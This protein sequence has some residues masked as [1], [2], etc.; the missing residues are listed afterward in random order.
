[1]TGRNYNCVVKIETGMMLEA[2]NRDDLF[3][4]VKEIWKDL[5]DITLQDCEIA[6]CD[7]Q[8]LE[9]IYESTQ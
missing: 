1:M 7:E 8:E 6:I 9:K 2:K 3:K 4:K 5:H